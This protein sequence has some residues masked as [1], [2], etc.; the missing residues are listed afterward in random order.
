VNSAQNS[1]LFLSIPFKVKKCSVKRCIVQ[2]SL[3]FSRRFFLL[4]KPFFFGFGIF[5]VF[6]C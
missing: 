6:F 1:I 5:R 2:K 3:I 4:K